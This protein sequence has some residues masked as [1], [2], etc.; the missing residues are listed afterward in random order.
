ME[1]QRNSF[2][3]LLFQVGGSKYDQVHLTSYPESQ[4]DATYLKGSQ[5]VFFCSLDNF[6]FICLIPFWPGTELKSRDIYIH[7]LRTFNIILQVN[8][9]VSDPVPNGW[10]RT[11]F[12]TNPITF[13]KVCAENG[14]C[15]WSKICLKSSH[16]E[17][18]G[19]QRFHSPRMRVRGWDMVN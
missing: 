19:K 18:Y 1:L 4:A 5:P 17:L 9:F 11:H 13:N 16:F 3:L 12:K 6:L 15:Y 14:Q 7:S 2:F 10:Q 8:P